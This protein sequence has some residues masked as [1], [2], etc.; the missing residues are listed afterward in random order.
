MPVYI[1][2]CLIYLGMFGRFFGCPGLVVFLVSLVVRL[3]LDLFF[4]LRFGVY[5]AN[6]LEVWF[7]VGVLEGFKLP[8]GGVYD[9]TV[10]FLR[11][12][13]LLFPGGLAFYGVLLSAAFLS[14]LTA[15]LVYV[16]V[17]ELY[18]VRSGFVAGLVYGGMV[19]PLGLSMSGF[20]HDHL[21]LALMVASMVFAVKAVK[22][23]WVGGFIW[24]AAYVAVAEAGK[25]V[26]FSMNMMISVS[27]THLTLPTIYSV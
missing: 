9:P 12:V 20:T 21:Q 7:Y 5:A 15:Y 23:G 3:L 14:S 24:S 16:L 2:R 27:Y 4:Q 25:N 22:S 19:E 10:W 17:R 8:A 1:F 18:D 26:N 11:L 13:G 6:H